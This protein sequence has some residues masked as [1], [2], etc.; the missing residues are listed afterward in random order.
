MTKDA[1][2]IT[3]VVQFKGPG[4]PAVVI[5]GQADERVIGFP[6]ISI[7]D[8][9]RHFLEFDIFQRSNV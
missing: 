1:G 7:E 8:Q 9:Y 3:I 6:S 2:S 4:F 5:L